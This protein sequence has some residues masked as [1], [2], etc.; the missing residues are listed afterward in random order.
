MRITLYGALAGVEVLLMLGVAATASART[1]PEDPIGIG[2]LFVA[3]ES[4][5]AGLTTG[6][7]AG[8]L[9]ERLVRLDHDVLEVARV[10]AGRAEVSPAVLRLDLFEDVALNAVVERKARPRPDTGSLVKSRDG[11]WVRMPMERSARRRATTG[12]EARQPDGRPP[13]G[14][15]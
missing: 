6:P 13:R 1:Q 15:V 9:R 11:R 14:A 5:T 4:P 2:N 7:D 3:E 8:V 10:N 12:R